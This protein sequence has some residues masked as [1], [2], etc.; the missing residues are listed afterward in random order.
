MQ[1]TQR[2][3]GLIQILFPT[4]LFV[5]YPSGV[6]MRTPAVACPHPEIVGTALMLTVLLVPGDIVPSLQNTVIPFVQPL[7]AVTDVEPL[8]STRTAKTFRASS[9]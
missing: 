3:Y 4:A 8:G 2:S 6:V 1:V 5:K 9:S 7:G